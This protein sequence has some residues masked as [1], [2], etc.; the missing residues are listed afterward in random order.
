MRH[1]LLGLL[2]KEPAHGYELKRLLEER[3]GRLWPTVNIGQVYTTLRRLERDGLVRSAEVAQSDR[4]DKRVFELTAAGQDELDEWLGDTT[5]EVRVKEPFFMKL[6][7]AANGAGRDPLV[8][9]DRYRRALL[10]RLRQVQALDDAGATPLERMVVEGAVLHL[11][12][13]VRWLEACEELLARDAREKDRTEEA[14][15]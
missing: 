13:D 11:Q 3:L 15:W 6:A 2:A 9:I 14:R 8:L 1:V 12:A 10:R 5:V 4:R 7:V